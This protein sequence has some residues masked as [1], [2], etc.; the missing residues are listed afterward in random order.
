[1]QKFPVIAYSKLKDD[2]SLS[3]WSPNDLVLLGGHTIAR[4]SDMK[5]A[6]NVSF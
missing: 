4:K 5:R 2:N 1:M 3:I 6:G